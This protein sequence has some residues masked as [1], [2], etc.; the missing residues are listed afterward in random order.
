MTQKLICRVNAP[1]Q[2]SWHMRL[3][4]L[5]ILSDCCK[6]I[7]FSHLTEQQE[8]KSL[9]DYIHAYILEVSIFTFGI[10]KGCIFTLN[11]LEVGIETKHQFCKPNLSS[12]W[13]SRT[14]DRY[15]D[16]IFCDFCQFL[17]KKLAL[18]S[19][20]NVMIKFLQKQGLV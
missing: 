4:F 5:L 11:I 16:D 15:Y 13:E 17:A 1:L 10:L 14:R 12:I 20:P 8:S 7:T 18:F 19:K 9:P 3:S 6:V 2:G